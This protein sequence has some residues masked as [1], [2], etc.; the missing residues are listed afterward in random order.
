MCNMKLKIEID[1]KNPDLTYS[2]SVFVFR[3]P[4][5]YA[6]AMEIIKE[7]TGGETENLCVSFAWSEC[8]GIQISPSTYYQLQRL[9]DDFIEV[10]YIDEEDP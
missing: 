6:E 9:A 2:R 5:R 4:E 3:S 10:P 8:P 7:D 1:I